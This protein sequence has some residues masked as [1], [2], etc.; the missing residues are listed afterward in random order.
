[1]KKL[2][3]ENDV[4]RVIA[5]GRR[6]IV[7]DSNSVLTPLAKDRIQSAGLTIAES[8]EKS[9]EL[10]NGEDHGKKIFRTI[11]VGSDHTGFELKNK[12]KEFIESFEIKVSDVGTNS[13]VSCDYPDFAYAAAKIV[14]MREADGAIIFDATGIPS[15][16]TANKIAGI[17]AVTCY[18][19]FSALSSRSHNN[20]NVLVLGAKTLGEE[21]VKSIIKTWLTTKFEG[22]RHQRRLDKI[23]QIEDK[24]T[25]KIPFS[26]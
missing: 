17:R 3:T 7:V 15:A 18:N 10:Q 19:E 20:A 9:I 1:M 21:T 22:G 8:V 12:L 4:L 5:D 26:Q 6:E 11:A 25:G 13:E 16:I 24:Y 14:A 23:T 2:I